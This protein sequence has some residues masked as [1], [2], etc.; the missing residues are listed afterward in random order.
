MRS[1]DDLKKLENLS[2]RRKVHMYAQGL[3]SDQWLNV[4]RDNG[5]Q[6]LTNC[7]VTTRVNLIMVT[8]VVELNVRLNLNFLSHCRF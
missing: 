1:G 4:L 8:Y 6:I 3:D 7:Y 5:I 2:S